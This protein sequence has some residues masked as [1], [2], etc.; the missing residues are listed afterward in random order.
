MYQQ[1]REKYRVKNFITS[2]LHQR[3][4]IGEAVHILL[5]AEKLIKICK[6][7]T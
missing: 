5:A 2:V 6:K 1:D 7:K 4:W 3:E